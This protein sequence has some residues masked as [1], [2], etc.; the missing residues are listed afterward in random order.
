MVGTSTGGSS[1]NDTCGRNQARHDFLGLV[2]RWGT[3]REVASVS[4]QLQDTERWIR[5]ALSFEEHWDLDRQCGALRVPEIA[6]CLSQALGGRGAEHRRTSVASMRQ[7]ATR[8]SGGERHELEN[9]VCKNQNASF[10]IR[11]CLRTALSKPA[12][13]LETVASALGNELHVLQLRNLCDG[14]QQQCLGLLNEHL[15]GWY[16]RFDKLMTMV[17]YSA[18][19]TC[20][21]VSTWPNSGIRQ[22][23]PAPAPTL[24]LEVQRRTSHH[25]DP[26]SLANGSVMSHLILDDLLHHVLQAMLTY[27]TLETS[28]A[29][30]GSWGKS[31]AAAEA[32]GVCSTFVVATR[33]R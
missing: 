12:N 31:W 16:A 24:P 23:F 33:G 6:Q 1:S 7:S 5:F 17:R 20:L 8:D 11:R 30:T 10:E 19:G 27:C 14:L 2:E 3:T 21:M 25:L 28:C 26:M 18:L 4:H 29:L 9:P 15:V 13:E 22:A 32:M